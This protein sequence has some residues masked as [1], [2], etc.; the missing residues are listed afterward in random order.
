MVNM[1]APN[2][3]LDQFAA[4]LWVGLTRVMQRMKHPAGTLSE[5]YAL[6]GQQMFA[7]WR[8]AETGPLTMSE[9]AQVF[10]VSHGVATRMVDR[11][12]A[13]GM[14]ERSGDES[15]RRVVLVSI[16]E[17]GR[18]VADEAISDVIEILKSV[19]KDVSKEDRE[20]YLSLLNRIAEVQ[21]NA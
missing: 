11:L 8:I 6:T 15:D 7:L 3:D 12:H 21:E 5:Q 20:E 19:F 17:L 14:V 1:A 10:D 13:K 2:G 16:S 4:D 18:Q 9:I